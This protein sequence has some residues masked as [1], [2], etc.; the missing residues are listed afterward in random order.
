MKLNSNECT[1]NFLIATNT[2]ILNILTR[3]FV[4]KKIIKSVKKITRINVIIRAFVAVRK[5]Q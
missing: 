5:L 2:R 3:A 1:N 4:A